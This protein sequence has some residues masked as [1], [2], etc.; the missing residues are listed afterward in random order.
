M[1]VLG[2]LLGAALRRLGGFCGFHFL[3]VERL[4]DPVL[5]FRDVLVVGVLVVLQIRPLAEQ[6]VHVGHGVVV[7]GIYAE[8]LLEIR[9]PIL[10]DRS[11]L[12][13]QLGAN[14][15]ILDWTGL[16]GLHAERGTRGHADRVSL[17][18][19]D[20]AEAIVA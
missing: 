20:D 16:F 7:V 17:Q 18:P 13:L 5:G 1:F 14:L 11:V 19:V 4:L 9:D 8:G 10:Y 12:F 6:E 2:V 3:G 15:L